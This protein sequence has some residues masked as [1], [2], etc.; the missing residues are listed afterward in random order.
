MVEDSDEFNA[1]VTN[2]VE[3]L[4]LKQFVK[5]YNSA[6]HDHSETAPFVS[7]KDSEDDIVSYACMILLTLYTP[8]F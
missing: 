1:I 8:N 4:H 5:K 7:K 3:R 2:P 6:T